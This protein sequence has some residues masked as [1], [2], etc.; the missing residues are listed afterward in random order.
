MQAAENLSEP[1]G[2][3]LRRRNEVT[4]YEGRF[5]FAPALKEEKR[6]A[7]TDTTA[8]WDRGNPTIAECGVKHK[9][10]KRR[11]FRSPVAFIKR[12]TFPSVLRVSCHTAFCVTGIARD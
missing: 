2:S 1:I 10:Q 3:L 4:M 6:P 8:L 11:H 9:A 7:L 12:T 5:M